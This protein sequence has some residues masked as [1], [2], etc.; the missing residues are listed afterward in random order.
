MA[1][2]PVR[3]HT[4]V[5]R[6]DS[7]PEKIWPALADTARFNEAAELPKYRIDE[8]PQPDGSVVYTGRAKFG[9]FVIAWREMPVEWVTNQRFRHARLFHNGPFKSLTATLTLT[10]EGEGSRADYLLE[11]EPA[12]RLG[13]LILAAGFFRNAGKTFTR[14]AEDAKAYAAGRA[15]R[16]FAVQPAALSADAKTRLEAGLRQLEDGGAPAALARRLG[17]FLIEAQEVDL[18]HIRP[19][20]LARDWGNPEREAIKLCLKAVKAGLLSMHWDLLCPNCRGPKAAVGALDQLPRGAHCNTCNIDYERDFARNVELTFRPVPTVRPVEAG[21]F[22]LFGPM[23]TP[24]VLVQQTL[25]PG[26]SR[27]LPAALPF[28]D[29]RLR[30]LH[31]G[32]ETLIAWTAGG[33]PALLATPAG[34]EAG[35]PAAPDHV[36][37]AN[38]LDREATL[39]IESRAWVRDALTAHRA[40]SMQAFRDLFSTDV[41]RPGDEVAISEVALMFTDLRGSTALYGRIGDGPAYR[42][43]REHY[44]FLAA[45]V[46]DHDGAI[47]KTIGDAVMAAFGDPAD[48]LA[49]GLAVQRNVWRFNRDHGA[50][51]GEGIVIK[52]GLHCGPCIAVT[53]NDRLDYFGSTVNLAARL[54]GESAGADIVISASMAADPAVARLLPGLQARGEQAA[55]KGFASPVAFLR[56]PAQGLA[57]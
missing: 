12:N 50:P 54:Q 27:D 52:L 26:E 4:W 42:L 1:K 31:P 10:P 5:W 32:G 34:V 36:R 2:T 8:T 19:R 25:A 53:L 6:F 45:S 37:L 3:A 41:L 55:V 48:A 56:I 13:R 47:V 39:V 23:T 46:R 51:A 30:G 22:C 9:P 43:V 16:P 7:P 57:V 29:Y 14:L 20:K 15:E 33:F 38:R 21:E 35:P 44:A 11:V 49:A 17:R 24:H 28:G 40:T 18:L